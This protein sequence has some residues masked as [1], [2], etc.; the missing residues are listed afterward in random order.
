MEPLL[1]K[2]K[3]KLIQVASKYIYFLYKEGRI[4]GKG[5][6]GLVYEG[7]YQLNG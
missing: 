7:E 2:N 6:A 1:K 3:S 4:I 5:S